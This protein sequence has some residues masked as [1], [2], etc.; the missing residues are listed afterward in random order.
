MSP[1]ALPANLLDRRAC[2]RLKPCQIKDFWQFPQSSA[3]S[4]IIS[5]GATNYT[6]RR[7]N[8]RMKIK[9]S[10]P[11]GCFIV[12][13]FVV[14]FLWYWLSGELFRPHNT[15]IV[16]L[17]VV[18]S[19]GRPASNA[20]LRLKQSGDRIIIP[21]PFAGLG[22]RAE[23]NFEEMADSKGYCHFTFSDQICELIEISSAGKTLKVIE[24]QVFRNSIPLELDR[25]LPTWLSTDKPYVHRTV[26]SPP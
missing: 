10:K 24:N 13:L 18:Y 7:R 12:F 1:A 3:L 20:V 14:G 26:V 23:S 4:D 17:T 19:D 21:I 5:A 2:L 11:F 6:V 22:W 16:E 8:N 25:S 9:R 15:S